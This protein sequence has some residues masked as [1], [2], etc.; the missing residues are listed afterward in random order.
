MR[1]FTVLGRG[2]DSEAVE[3]YLE[4]VVEC[5]QTAEAAALVVAALADAAETRERAV[6]EADGIRLEAALVAAA[7]HREASA[8][9]RRTH[10]DLVAATPYVSRLAEALAARHDDIHFTIDA[11][12]MQAIPAS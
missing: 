8:A 10:A 7:V 12:A 1:E 9:L 2:C 4:A 3:A 6:E 11:E 5:V